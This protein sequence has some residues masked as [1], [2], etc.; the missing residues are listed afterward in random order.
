MTQWKLYQRTNDGNPQMDIP[1]RRAMLFLTYIQG[2]DTT[3]WV[4]AMS[5]WL[6][7]QV[8]AN[9]IDRHNQGLWHSTER[10]F[11]RKFADVLTQERALAT[12]KAGIKMEKGDLDGFISKF[13]QLTRH[14]GLRVNEPMVLDKFT[15]GLPNTMYRE[16]YGRQ[17]PPV[18]Y[19]EWRQEAI[20]HHKKWTHFQ[21][22]LDAHRTKPNPR[23]TNNNW[24]GA[25]KIPHDPNAMDT[26]PGRTRA[27]V[28]TDED[29]QPGGYRWPQAAANPANQGN[30]QRRD[31]REVTC[32][33]CNKKGHYARDC[34]TETPAT[35]KTPV[36]TTP[37]P[38]P[39]TTSSGGITACPRCGR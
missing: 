38:K 17:H 22:R 4:N 27:R 9:G 37:W 34:Q 2:G 19:E 20:Q 26:S 35:T 23:P 14:A 18:T 25:L 6:Y 3:E 5:E 21:G 15:S 36:A 7:Q 32:F 28:A 39:S 13:E 16:L 12:L 8:T 10:S 30:K 29:F 24:R 11:N 33:C 31:I 1:Y